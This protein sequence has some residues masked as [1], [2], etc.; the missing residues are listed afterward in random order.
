MLDAAILIFSL[1][2]LRRAV[3]MR[4]RLGT[5]LAIGMTGLWILVGVVG[6]RE[7]AAE[8]FSIL[9]AWILA[10]FGPASIGTGGF[11]G[12]AGA[13]LCAL[14]GLVAAHRRHVSIPPMLDA[15]VPWA[16]AAVAFVPPLALT[17]GQQAIFLLGRMMD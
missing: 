3:V 11:V 5:A 13:T 2:A 4:W 9:G 1:R 12:R 17:F 6:W 8:R 10:L 15:S 7:H 14:A 16:D